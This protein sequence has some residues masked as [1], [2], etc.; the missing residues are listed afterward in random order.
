M[1]LT[2]D[3]TTPAWLEVDWIL[4][5]FS[6]QRKRARTKYINFVRKVI[7]LEPIWHNQRHQIYLGDEQFITKHQKMLNDK[8]SLY[9]IPM[10]QKRAVTKPIGNYQEQYKDKKQ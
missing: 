4:S 10:L 3:K 6:L 1:V 2:G 9:V 5:H 7:G 8:A